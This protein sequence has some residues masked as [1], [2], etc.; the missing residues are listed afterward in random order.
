MCPCKK[1]YAKRKGTL[2]SLLLAS[3]PLSPFLSLNQ[4]MMPYAGGHAKFGSCFMSA[5]PSRFM[6]DE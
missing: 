2:I 5:F 4:M 1:S 6:S 3:D